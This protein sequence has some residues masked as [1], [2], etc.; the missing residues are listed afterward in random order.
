MVAKLQEDVSKLQ[1]NYQE[2]HTV[3]EQRMKWAVGANPDL[4][5]IFDAYSS[6]IAEEMESMK[7]LL[8][9][10]KGVCRTAN[11]VLH[12]E[13]LRTNQTSE[14]NNSDSA[15]VALVAEC[16][17]SANLLHTQ[18]ANKALSEQEL[19]LFKMNPPKENGLVDFVIDATWIRGTEGAIANRVKGVHD[20]LSEGNKRMNQ[21]AASIG[22]SVN[23]LQRV[24]SIHSKLLADV[25]SLIASMNKADHYDVPQ[26]NNYLTRSTWNGTG[27]RFT[28]PTPL[29]S[30]CVAATVEPGSH[31]PWFSRFTCSA[32]IP[33]RRSRTGPL[34]T[35]WR[36]L[37]RRI[38]NRESK[39]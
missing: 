1:S 18:T 11:T 3:I 25:R 17:N 26:I 35:Q 37:G 23:E 7:V 2:K 27:R 16:Q 9:N 24:A 19:F 13:A 5:D 29:A 30:M 28:T 8:A 4:N 22:Q 10:A 38:L 36:N 14:S 6:A 34:R 33:T 39:K 20:N 15:F 32:T 31:P 12:Y 21:V